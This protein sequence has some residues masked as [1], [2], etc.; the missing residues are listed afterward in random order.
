MAG[1]DY[2][3]KVI[4]VTGGASGLGTAFCKLLAKRGARVGVAD[5]Q[6][7]KAMAVADDIGGEAMGFAVDTASLESVE[8][9]ADAAWSAFGR[10]D[11]IFNNAGVGGGGR[12]LVKIAP[13]DF[14][15]IWSVNVKGVWHGCR[16]F[17]ARFLDQEG[18]ALIVNTGSEHALG[19][20]HLNNGAYTGAK[21]A[22]LG[23]TDVL[24]REMPERVQVSV[25][26]PGLTATD[27]W[28][29]QAIRPSEFGGPVEGH[30]LSRAVMDRGMDPLDVAG[31]A[32]EAIASGAF[33]VITHP[34]NR[35]MVEDRFTEQRAALESQ[36][37]GI[38]G[39]GYDVNDV[40]ADVLGAR[41]PKRP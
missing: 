38:D 10:V 18:P 40:L 25:F 7:E 27:I 29:A 19:V 22:V 37:K 24:R 26:C 28:N 17:G 20:P 4:V 3:G 21:H 39:E 2:V 35:A 11:G 1:F 14:D 9:L 30:P 36:N 41:A 6:A 33:Y 15:W 13:E 34:H 5:V 12:Q 8:A 31:R 23:M 32:L 16:V